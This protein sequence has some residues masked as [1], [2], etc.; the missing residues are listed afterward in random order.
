MNL[1]PSVPLQA[2]SPQGGS[3]MSFYLMLAVLGLIWFFL[4]IRP[5]QQRQK[6]HESSLGAA[7]K[8]DHVVTSGGLHGKIAGVGDSDFMVEIASLKGGGSVR[9]KIDKKHI[10]RVTKPGDVKKEG[11]GS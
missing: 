1:F 4:V 9:V 11:E 8:G 5:Q 2:A 7:E 6:K 10:E 3:G